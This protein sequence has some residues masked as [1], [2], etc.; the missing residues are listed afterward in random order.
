MAPPCPATWQRCFT[1]NPDVEH[2]AAGSKMA[3]SSA[4]GLGHLAPRC[5]ACLACRAGQT[6]LE[7]DRDT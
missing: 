2:S 6:V 1:I 5:G 7:Q 3:P 4:E